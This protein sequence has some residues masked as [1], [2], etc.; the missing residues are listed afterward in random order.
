MNQLLSVW[1]FA[2]PEQEHNGLLSPDHAHDQQ[3]DQQHDRR[4][5]RNPNLWDTSEDSGIRKAADNSQS[6]PLSASEQ[7]EAS[8]CGTGTVKDVQKS[9][10][11]AGEGS[12]G[13]R[14]R[15]AADDWF[16]H[17]AFD[18]EPSRDDDADTEVPALTSKDTGVSRRQNRQANN[19]EHQRRW[20]L[21]QKVWSAF[22]TL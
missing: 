17:Q 18:K 12:Q 7:P 3:H 5:E 15:E 10:L 6:S 22:H 4:R 20:R 1:S 21:R 9:G 2:A 11:Q 13:L 8:T 19:R 14:S 16:N